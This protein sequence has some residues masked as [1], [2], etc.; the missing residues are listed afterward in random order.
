MDA[1]QRRLRMNVAMYES[2]SLFAPWV[3]PGAAFKA[4]NAEVPPAGGE[5]GFGKLADCSGGTHYSHYR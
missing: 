3:G 2:H 4:H 5:I 1:D